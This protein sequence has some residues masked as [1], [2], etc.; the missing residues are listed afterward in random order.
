MTAQSGA[1]GAKVS[2]GFT[3]V[4]LVT[5]AA[6]AAI[7]R[8]TAYLSAALQFVFPFSTLVMAFTYG[9]FVM[10]AAVIVR[11]V[12]VFTMFTIAGC[13]INYFQGETLLPLLTMALEG[14]LADIYLYLRLRA[15]VN[16]WGS[17]REMVIASLLSGVTWVIVTYAFN[18]PVFWQV[19]LPLGMLALLCVLG[20]AL[21][22]FGGVLGFGLGNK[23]KGLIG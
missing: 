13:L 18:F 2:R 23:I 16:P 4:D 12:G 8:A 14:V 15:G 11:K 22:V 6:L 1:K 5:I 17:L 19:A 10:T 7:F 3:A 9:L 21:E 20:I